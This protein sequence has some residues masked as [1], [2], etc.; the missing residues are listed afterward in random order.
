MKGRLLPVRAVW[1]RMA[2]IAAAIFLAA[3]AFAAP[4]AVPAEPRLV[5]DAGFHGAKVSR[6]SASAD[7][8]RLLTASF[9]KTARLY[10]EAGRLLRVLRVPLG[11]GEEGR[12]DSCAL[13]PDGRTAAL[14]GW[15]GFDFESK[16]SIYLFDCATGSLALRI[17]DLPSSAEHLAFAPGAKGILACGLGGSRGVRVFDST[18]GA[19]L[20][21]DTDFAGNCYG[22]AWSVDGSLLAA[23]GYDGF[24]RL[25]KRSGSSFALVMK[26]EAKSGKQAFGLSFGRS[27]ADTLLA[28]GFA[29]SLGTDIYVATPAGLAYS[30]SPDAKGLSG[31]NLCHV[32][33]AGA[34]GTVP[35][36]VAG[37]SYGA[38]DSPL[39][40][41]D[42]AGRGARRVLATGAL[43]AV[44]DIQ[45][46]VDGGLLLGG[47]DPLFARLGPDLSIKFA[48]KSPIADY[49][50]LGS[51]FALAPDGSAVNFAYKQGAKE[52]ASFSVAARALGAP[53]KDY[54][55]A[56]SASLVAFGASPTLNG[57]PLEL[58]AG[59]GLRCA[60][61]SP[62]RQRF[63]LGT[64]YY[65]RCVG[66][67]AKK[68]WTV[69]PS[70]TTWAVDVSKDGRIGAAAYSNG[71]IRWYRMDT[72]AELLAFYPHP[73]KV[74]WVAWTPSGYYAASAGAEELIGWHL[75]NGLEKAPDF[76][77]VSR[78]RSVY[79]RPDVV[80]LVA[81]T[82][83]EKAAL[84]QA[85]EASGRK[86]Q[87]PGAGSGTALL[88]KLP[89]S[90]SIIG[91]ASGSSFSGSSVRIT[92]RASAPAD[93]QVTGVRALVD[94]RPAEGAKGLAVVAA[95]G[96]DATID[97]PVPQ[98]NC[99]VSLI[100]DNRNGS[101]EAATIQL[102]RAVAA[103]ASDEFVI[104]PKLYV[105]A[106]G[107]SAYANP[108]YRLAY[109]AKDARDL[110]AAFAGLKGNVYRDVE[111]RVLA[112][113]DATKDN[114]LDGLD[115]IQRQTTSKDVAVMFFSGHG[116]NDAS[117]N[118]YYLPVGTNLDGLKR[119]GVPFSDITTTVSAIAGKVL[120]FIDTCHSG[121]LMKGRKA[122]GTER[123]IV[124]VVNEL[125]SAE[126]GAVV[127]ASSTGSQYSYEDPSWGNGAFTKALIEG[128]K[129]AAAYGTGD[130][131]TVN[132]LD[133][134]ISE[135][136]KALTGGKQTPTTTK[137]ANVPDFPIATRQK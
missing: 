49:R 34:P 6:V 14:S 17:K 99:T 41:W 81:A 119:T 107:V 9:D 109:A 89:P 60:A 96:A 120:F 116:I 33:F 126:N 53:S 28:V 37:G 40:V 55:A 133:L 44:T 105:L 3:G 58:S 114:I 7:G 113:A 84:A 75:N 22:L 101:S 132:M 80:G 76:Y 61:A 47:A 77:P 25:Y 127:F 100:A 57:A 16:V 19:E 1:I 135:R 11:G 15:T 128:L 12:L 93:A 24:V 66:A 10:D 104:K 94:G 108:D 111:S 65:L 30:F 67:D 70:G 20:F 123:D 115:W 42:A 26:T 136:V 95:G 134:Y 38:N 82:L 86:A 21:R 90:V 31:G 117:Q 98:R 62:D 13:T 87:A 124:A 118:Y 54:V 88:A 69:S 97:V 83:D 45:T 72:G 79:Y 78:F 39:V 92:Y 43:D 103:A 63:L 27:G 56:G 64:D 121:N 5:L 71:T 32:A 59:E 4:V 68:L 110:A 131:I 48:L 29:D 52:P 2:A 8:T 18:S 73:D 85:D 46:L 112:D 137:P 125:A 106:V 122:V 102:V 23:S 51:V 35:T 130:R 36:L 50:N 74:R 91:P 129:G